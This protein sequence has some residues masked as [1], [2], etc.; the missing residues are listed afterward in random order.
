M[1]TKEYKLDNVIASTKL[2]PIEV[3]HRDLKRYG[4]SAF[5]SEC[6]ECNTGLLLVGRDATTFKLQ[7]E[8]TCT[9]CS[10]KFIYTD[11]KEEVALEYISV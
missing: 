11:I 4:D 1:T 10:R 8:D 2:P 7:K 5:K 6:P 3:R 9:Y